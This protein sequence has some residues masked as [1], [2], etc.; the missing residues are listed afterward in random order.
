LRTQWSAEA[1]TKSTLSHSWITVIERE[2]NSKK[3]ASPVIPEIANVTIVS[4]VAI[5]WTREDDG[6]AGAVVDINVAA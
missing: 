6:F 5:F 3:R 1:T 2:R 4:G